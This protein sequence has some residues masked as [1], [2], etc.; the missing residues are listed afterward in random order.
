MRPQ[1]NTL[2][3]F[4]WVLKQYKF[5]HPKAARLVGSSCQGSAASGWRDIPFLI[6]HVWGNRMTFRE[7]ATSAASTTKDK[8]GASA[9]AAA[10]ATTTSVA[11]NINLCNM[12]EISRMQ[13]GAAS[14]CETSADRKFNQCWQ[15]RQCDGRGGECCNE[16]QLWR[17]IAFDTTATTTTQNALQEQPLQEWLQGWWL[18]IRLRQIKIEYLWHGISAYFK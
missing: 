2:V 12:G 17:G 8:A 15:W 4:T 5:P 6:A 14:S 7:H 1:W 16:R 9:A 3:D 13:R 11:C 18:R 10:M